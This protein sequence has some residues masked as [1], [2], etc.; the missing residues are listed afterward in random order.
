MVSAAVKQQPPIVTVSIADHVNEPLSAANRVNGP[1]I[2]RF[3]AE[4][5]PCTVLG[6]QKEHKVGFRQPGVWQ[7]VDTVF[8]CKLEKNT[9]YKCKQSPVLC[10][11]C[12][13]VFSP[14]E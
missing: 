11:K 1:L 3:L 6:L 14:V 5:K 8:S 4:R 2:I 7:S 9:D 10:C 12:V 13:S